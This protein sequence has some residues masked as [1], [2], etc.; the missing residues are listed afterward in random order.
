MIKIGAS[1]AYPTP[2]VGHAEGIKKSLSLVQRGGGLGRKGE[3]VGLVKETE[4]A[5]EE[6]FKRLVRETELLWETR[7]KMASN[8]R[9]EAE[10]RWSALTNTVTYVYVPPLDSYPSSRGALSSK[11]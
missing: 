8:R 9:Q 2:T 5:L 7:E 4:N 10:R 1:M 3:D 6:D 11:Y